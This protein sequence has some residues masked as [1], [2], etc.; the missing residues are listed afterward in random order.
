MK[1]KGCPTLYCVKLMNIYFH[2]LNI[3]C[4]HVSAIPMILFGFFFNPKYIFNVTDLNIAGERILRKYMQPR[5]KQTRNVCKTSMP[6][7]VQN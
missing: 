7:I 4:I 1:N 6:P 2:I 3:Q 5:G